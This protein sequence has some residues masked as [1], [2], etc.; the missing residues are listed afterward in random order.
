MKIKPR[1]PRAITSM[2]SQRDKWEIQISDMMSMPFVRIDLKLNMEHE[3]INNALVEW[4]A[5]RT[6]ITSYEE[7]LKVEEENRSELSLKA[8]M[9]LGK[10]DQYDSLNDHFV[11]RM[12]FLLQLPDEK[13]FFSDLAIA[14]DAYVVLVKYLLNDLNG[15]EISSLINDRILALVP[16][17]LAK[18]KIT[19]DEKLVI[20]NK[21]E[22]LIDKL[23]KIQDGLSVEK[24]NNLILLVTYVVY[25]YKYF[26]N[27][28]KVGTSLDV[29]NYLYKMPQWIGSI[30]LNIE[31]YIKMDFSLLCI[32]LSFDL[33][34]WSDPLKTKIGISFETYHSLRYIL[35]DTLQILEKR[36]TSFYIPIYQWFISR[37][38]SDI[39]K[40]YANNPKLE[41]YNL[42]DIE[43]MKI[44]AC[45]EKFANYRYPVTIE[46]V[47]S[48]LM[49]FKNRQNAESTIRILD[50]IVFL[51][52]WQLAERLEDALKQI[53]NRDGALAICPLGPVSGSTSLMHYYMAHSGIKG[54]TF[55]NSVTE[56]IRSN[57][58]EPTI[59]FIDDCALTGIQSN[60]IFSILMGC[61]KPT[62]N[63]ML[64]LSD[65]DKREFFKRKIAVGLSIVSDTAYSGLNNTFKSLNLSD[66]YVA[67]G[68]MTLEN[69]KAFSHSSRVAWKDNNERNRMRLVF[70][71]IGMRILSEKARE[72]NW[73]QAELKH[74]SLGF[75]DFQSLLVFPYSVPKPTITALWAGVKDFS[76]PWVPL[77]P[78]AIQDESYYPVQ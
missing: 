62:D 21:L 67:Y 65:E 25:S 42:H 41:Y 31:S 47:V 46:T 59:C 55:Y 24:S 71:K 20:L 26:C 57:E 34:S 53:K 51:E 43:R 76:S 10:K 61:M 45:C 7:Y 70:Q 44:L 17:L 40:L 73:S 35:D 1:L 54:V 37:I 48:Y 23:E 8:R 60:K 52:F 50:A 77:F 15:D 78:L 68:S 22:S 13:L 33:I 28:F 9:L 56:A 2:R 32:H 19:K 11:N 66:A 64:I 6:L 63:E 29:V 30:Y 39:T 38:D 27:Q 16:A 49:Q 14:V 18:D 4:Q 75:G 3:A 36:N 72:K 58:K 74:H 5:N 69:D 12:L